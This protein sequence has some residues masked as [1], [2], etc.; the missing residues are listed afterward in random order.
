VEGIKTTIPVLR[1]LM[2]GKVDTTHIQREFSKK[3]G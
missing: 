2:A 1:D 3:E